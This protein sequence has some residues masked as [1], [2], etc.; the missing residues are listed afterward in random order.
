M[1]LLGVFVDRPGKVAAGGWTAIYLISY[2]THNLISL[3][4]IIFDS[5]QK[6][7]NQV[8]GLARLLLALF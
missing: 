3:I 5:R 8:T 1:K 2:V 6:P 7:Q 4:M